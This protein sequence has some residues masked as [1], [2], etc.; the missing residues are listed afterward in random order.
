MQNYKT[1]N[2]CK[3]KTHTQSLCSFSEYRREWFG[4]P[5]S[6]Q[7]HTKKT[8]TKA[9]LVFGVTAL[10]GDRLSHIILDLRRLIGLKVRRA[11]RDL[12]IRQ[13]MRCF[14]LNYAKALLTCDRKLS[15]FCFTL[16]NYG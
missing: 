7:A 1:A 12:L 3:K 14:L 6:K 9:C 2:F 4:S 5:I 10:V 8:K 13:M 16:V 11:Y 15:L